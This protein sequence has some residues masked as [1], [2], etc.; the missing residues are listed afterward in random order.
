MTDRERLIQILR[1]PIHPHLDADPAEVVADYLLDN[2]VTF[3]PAVPGHEDQYNISEMA[4]NNGYEKGFADGQREPVKRGRWIIHHSGH[5]R[6]ATNWAECSECCVCGSPQW[7]VCP[8]CEAK[9]EP[10]VNGYDPDELIGEY[11]DE[12][13]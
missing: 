7:K 8:V 4:Y 12:N 13:E 3:T 11:E 10:P 1:V 2:G 5:G 9:M 6:Y